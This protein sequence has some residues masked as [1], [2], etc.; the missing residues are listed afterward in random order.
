MRC[1]VGPPKKTQNSLLPTRGNDS[2]TKQIRKHSSN[3]P[4]GCGPTRCKNVEVFDP[5]EPPLKLGGRKPYFR[6]MISSLTILLEHDR[7]HQ[8]QEDMKRESQNASH[9]SWEVMVKHQEFGASEAPQISRDPLKAFSPEERTRFCAAKLHWG[10]EIATF[11]PGNVFVLGS[12]WFKSAWSK[13]SSAQINKIAC[14]Q[15]NKTK[16]C[17][18]LIC[19]VWL[20]C[21]DS[22]LNMLHILV[23]KIEHVFFSWGTR[24]SFRSTWCYSAWNTIRFVV[25]VRP[26]VRWEKNAC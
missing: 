4:S 11:P 9:E 18:G 3:A 17:K 24:G 22:N 16:T 10:R 7:N 21:H 19:K 26:G 13:T 15:C 20:S 5:K 6:L 12:R 23:V 8:T 2:D 14:Q 1:K 25:A